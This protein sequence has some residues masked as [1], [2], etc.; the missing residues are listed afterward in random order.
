[1]R[2]GSLHRGAGEGE[3]RLLAAVGRQADWIA[4][5]TSRLVRIPSENPPG[6]TRALVALVRRV[7]ADALPEAAVSVHRAAAPIDNVVAVLRGRTTGRRLVFNGHLDTY[8]AGDPSRWTYPP[9]SGKRIGGRIYG[10]GAADM[11]GG[12][13]CSLAAMRA[14]AEN[15]DLWSGELILTLAGDEESMGVLGSQHLLDSVEAARGD[16]MI[17]GDVGSPRVPRFGE[18]GM[19]WI[20]V[21][22]TGV[23]AHGAHVHRGVNAI[24]R[25]C[26]AMAALASLR[27]HPVA[28]PP[29]VDAAIEAARAV[30]EPLGGDGEGRVLR[31]V[32][33]NFGRI[34]GGVA[35]NLVCRFGVAHRRPPD[36]RG[37]SAS[38]SWSRRSRSSSARSQA[39]TSRSAAAT[40]R[41][42][43]I[44]SIPSSRRPRRPANGSSARRWRG[45]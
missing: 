29:R 19:I 6:D 27:G 34:E 40:R 2:R 5:L 4:D 10:R 25:L 9:F 7:L 44:P 32:S 15:R 43:P 37:G 21:H 12:I 35:T 38:R 26:A 1:M 39:S 30:S 18:K 41:A 22:A 13:A 31:Q 14:L 17:C 28:T 24:D 42:G 45:T 16:A 23:P 20:D 33:V 8:P 3:A 11:K 36:P